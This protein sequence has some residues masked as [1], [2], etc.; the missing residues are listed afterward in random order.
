M[1]GFVRSPAPAQLARIASDVAPG[2]LLVFTKRLIWSAKKRRHNPRWQQ[3]NRSR[4]MVAGLCIERML[5]EPAPGG[6]S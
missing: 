2:E 3:V 5:A 1:R 4:F 6:A